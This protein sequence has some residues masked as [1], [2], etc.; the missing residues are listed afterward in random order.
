MPDYRR[1]IAFLIKFSLGFLLLYW[2]ISSRNLDL[3][4]LLRARPSLFFVG[5]LILLFSGF[6]FAQ[7]IRWYTLLQNQGI[8]IPLL[9]CFNLLLASQFLTTFLPGTAGG[10]LYRSY[11]IIKFAPH[12]KTAALSTILIDRFLGLYA[13]LG[14]GSGFFLYEFL[15][16]GIEN[17][18]LFILGATIVSLCFIIPFIFFLLP[19]RIVQWF[20]S[21][22]LPEK[23]IHKAHTV[24][25]KYKHAPKILVWGLILSLISNTFFCLIFWVIADQLDNQISLFNVIF[26]LPFIIIAN[27]LPLTPGGV[28]V[29]ETTASLLFHIFNNT[30][31]AETMLLLRL[32]SIIFRLPGGFILLLS[33]PGKAISQ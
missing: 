19:G 8:Y 26:P 17:H 31:G 4:L 20:L 29:G 6:F 1:K 14:I 9:N 21:S 10:D 2:L 7:A 25:S 16:Y 18:T 27:T 13:F 33:R 11:Y 28:G 22:F 5:S 12:K 3:N 23:F 24:F 30:N 32:W 15:F